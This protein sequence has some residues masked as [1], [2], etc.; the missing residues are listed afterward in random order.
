[1]CLSVCVYVAGLIIAVRGFERPGG[2]F[3]VRDFVCRAWHRRPLP[4]HGTILVLCHSYLSFRQLAAG[5]FDVSLLC[6]CCVCEPSLLANLRLGR[7]YV[8]LCLG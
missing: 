1:M 5:I 4:Q 8:A 6:G 3:E 7:G 2:E